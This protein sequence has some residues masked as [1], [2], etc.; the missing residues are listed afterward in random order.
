MR[1]YKIIIVEDDE[2]DR[3]L[4]TE[5]FV[6]KGFND[7]LVLSSGP[8]LLSYLDSLDDET[9]LP[10]LIITDL[11][12]PFVSGF[13]LLRLIKSNPRYQQIEVIVFSTSSL[14]DDISKSTA[15]G[16]KQFITK[17]VQLSGYYNFIDE[18][19]STIAY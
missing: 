18:V 11:N 6:P 3:M 15:L 8:E 12:M 2:E 14:Q 16:A 19:T 17:P 7:F 1:K 5:A 10:H 13:D 9:Y 4:L